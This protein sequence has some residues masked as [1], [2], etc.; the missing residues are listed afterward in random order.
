M[1]ISIIKVKKQGHKRVFGNIR[2]VECEEIEDTTFVKPRPLTLAKFGSECR[3]S[4][5]LN[6][7]L[8]SV[9]I[10][11]FHCYFTYDESI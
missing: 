4:Q 3:N 10:H 7:E 2:L 9:K 8:K 6:V 5:K 1:N 11:F